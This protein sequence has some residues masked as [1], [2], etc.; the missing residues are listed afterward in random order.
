MHGADFAQDVL[1]AGA[2]A[3]LTDAE[4]A[5]RPALLAAK[6]PVLVLPDPRAVLGALAARIYGNPSDHLS[7]IGV[8]G[9]SG[10]TTTTYLVDAGLRAAGKI[11]GLIGTVQTA[12]AGERLASAFT[13]PEAPDLQALLA[14]TCSNRASRTCRWRSPATR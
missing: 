9:T 13:T 11:T 7:V 10:K 8:T 4:G 3:I 14:R 12:I 2:A 1:A 6:V 5:A